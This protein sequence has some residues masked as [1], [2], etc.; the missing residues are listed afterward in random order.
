MSSRSYVQKIAVV[1]KILGIKPPKFE[2]FGRFLAPVNCQLEDGSNDSIDNIEYWNVDVRKAWYSS[3]LPLEAMRVLVGSDKRKGYY[4]NQISKFFGK[5]EHVHLSRMI[6][7]WIEMAEITL[8]EI[9]Y[10]AKQFFT[11]LKKLRWII[12]QDTAVLIGV[13]KRNHS[14]YDSMPEIFKSK[15]FKSFTLLMIK[16]VNHSKYDDQNDRIIERFLPAHLLPI[17]Y[18]QSSHVQLTTLTIVSELPCDKLNDFMLSSYQSNIFENSP[19]SQPKTGYGT[20]KQF[21]PSL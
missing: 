9:N 13:H 6:F 16:H 21:P 19:Q 14:L 17:G 2:H 3:K 5:A 20:V 8:P 1:C 4:V 7:P 12:L 11:L 15:E 10:T 18:F